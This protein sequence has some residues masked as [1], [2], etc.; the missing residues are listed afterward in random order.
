MVQQLEVVLLDK[1][2]VFADQLT[3]FPILIIFYFLFLLPLILNLTWSIASFKNVSPLHW[4]C[5]VFRQC[6]WTMWTGLQLS[7]VRSLVRFPWSQDNRASTSITCLYVYLVTLVYL[8]VLYY[9][10]AIMGM[11]LFG[12]LIK[13][14]GSFP[15][16]GDNA[17]D[18]GNFTEF[19]GNI[20]LKDSDFYAD[21]YCNNN[22]NNILR[23]FKVLFD[24]M[25]VNQ[26]HSILWITSLSF[27]CLL[28]LSLLFD[29]LIF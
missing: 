1:F 22:F 10:Y 28:V 23:S 12:N 15:S 20:K 5:Q 27:L 7:A 2:V 21:R 3:L 19:C 16:T 8:Q 29:W 24:L 11:E 13:M 26:W 25:V 17:T 14:E 6:E 9:I 4:S 18:G